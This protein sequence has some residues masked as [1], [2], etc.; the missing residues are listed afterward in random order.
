MWD[1]EVAPLYNTEWFYFVNKEDIVA[2]M[3]TFGGK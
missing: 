1:F 2:L 3:L